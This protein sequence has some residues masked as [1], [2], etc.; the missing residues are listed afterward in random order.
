MLLFIICSRKSWILDS[1][2]L[3]SAERQRV[4]TGR[5]CLQ[6]STTTPASRVQAA[7]QVNP[8]ST[9]RQPQ[10]GHRA[11]GRGQ[12]SPPC[13]S[14]CP[15]ERARTQGQNKTSQGTVTCW[16]RRRGTAGGQLP[17]TTGPS[18]PVPGSRAPGTQQ[19]QGDGCHPATAAS[20]GRGLHTQHHSPQLGGSPQPVPGSGWGTKHTPQP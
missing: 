2:R 15:A 6:N 19:A 1:K 12:Q 13:T 10:P 8:V 20:T 18:P 17:H 7:R 4:S 11:C 14:C 16:P 9:E 3:Y 5:G